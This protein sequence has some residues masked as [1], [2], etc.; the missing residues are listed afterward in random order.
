VG[1]DR[2][3]IHRLARELARR[4][5][6]T[7]LTFCESEEQKRAPLPQDGVFAHVHR[8]VLPAWRSWLN[9]LLAL[10]GRQPLQVAYYQSGEFRKAVEALAPS[11]DVVLAHLVRTADYV[12]D[13]R[14]IRLLEMTDAI[15][16]SM[17]RVSSTKLGYF[18]LRRFVYAVE[19]GR[20]A[21]Y[22]RAVVR[23]FDL[24]SLNSPV[25]RSFL[26][27]SQDDCERHVI[28]APNGVDL[29]TALPPPI[30]AR[31][32]DEIVFVGNLYSLQ[33]FDAAWF[34]AEHVL[35]RVRERRPGAY[36][37]IIGPIRKWAAK[38]LAGLPGVHVE[39][40]VPDL[41]L[42]LSTARVGVCAARIC[43]GM[44]NKLLDYF[45]NRIAVVCSSNAFEGLEARVGE[46]LL[47]ADSLE[48][49]VNHIVRLLTDDLLAQRLADAGRTLA[50]E[51][52]RWARCA[53]PLMARLEHLVVER[54]A[55]APAK[56]LVP[57]PV[58]STWTE[59]D[60]PRSKSSA[61]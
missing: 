61:M 12:R 8:I 60:A 16:M 49:W 45:A 47:L 22:E 58:P 5:E 25:D 20:L 43:S 35:P 14:T 56:A 21:D 23:D 48:D 10:P 18:D 7:L 42:A 24:V 17:K 55:C 37:R 39:G 34:F 54:L 44:Q 13:M 29:P 3:R 27:N 6:L 57:P 51:H 30:T 32:P 1:G 28:V 59:I 2:L 19:S 41:T 50:G 31:R 53:A 52:Y 11:H 38:R 4:F 15:S 40:F 9:V 26:F 36:L 46:Q 33:N